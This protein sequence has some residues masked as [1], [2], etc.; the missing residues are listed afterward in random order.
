MTLYHP[1]ESVGLVDHHKLSSTEPPRSVPFRQRIRTVQ[2]G[3]V[4]PQRRRFRPL[5]RA[6]LL[7]VAHRTC[8]R[9]VGPCAVVAAYQGILLGEPT[10]RI[11]PSPFDSSCVAK[12]ARKLVL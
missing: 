1:L 6:R 3:H 12:I 9:L 8:L 10:G 2:H 4:R 5:I 11:V 7:L